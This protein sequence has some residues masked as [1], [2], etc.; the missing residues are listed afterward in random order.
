M[1]MGCNS[2]FLRHE[3]RHDLKNISDGKAQMLAIDF[4]LEWLDL[5]SRYAI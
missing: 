2:I 1:N 4:P 5:L 3:K